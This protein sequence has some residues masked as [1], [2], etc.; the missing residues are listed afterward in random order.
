MTVK[1]ADFGMVTT[2]HASKGSM[3][4]GSMNYIAPEVLD[5]RPGSY[6]AD[7]WSACVVIYALLQAVLPFDGVTHDQVRNQIFSMDMNVEFNG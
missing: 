4:I 6:K 5:F 2:E 7:V 1:L 3:Q